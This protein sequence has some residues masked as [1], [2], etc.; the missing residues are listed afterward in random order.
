MQLEYFQK[1][2]TRNA[3][4]IRCLVE[5]VSAE[6]ARWRPAPDEWSIL[7]V[8]N[9]LHDEE[10]EDFRLR[11]NLLL[12]FPNQA[13]PEIDPPG[14]AIERAYND[15][16]LA[17][18]LDSF[19]RARRESL[20]WLVAL[21]EPDWTVTTEH[22]ELGTMSAADLLAAWLAHDFLHLRQLADLRV[23]YL[24]YTVQPHSVAYAGL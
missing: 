22:P 21:V 19:L 4:T 5:G 14:W 11:L 16:D 20:V 7:E 6:Q 10:R 2:F 13:W 8:I 1:Q 15:R 17:A 3:T 18:S 23:A 12:H 24:A 9:H